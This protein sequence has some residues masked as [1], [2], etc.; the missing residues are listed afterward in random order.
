MMPWVFIG[1]S[2]AIAKIP[3]TGGDTGS[4][5]WIKVEAVRVINRILAESRA[6]GR[7]RPHSYSVAF[8]TGN[9]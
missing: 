6:T 5:G 3:V 1:R 8:A 4:T 7:W 2:S 9:A